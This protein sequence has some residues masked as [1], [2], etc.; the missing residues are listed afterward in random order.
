MSP[1]QSPSTF[2]LQSLRSVK[3]EVSQVD[4]GSEC[5]VSFTDFQAM[6]HVKSGSFGAA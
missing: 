2:L 5:G 4:A 3:E 6:L 1:A